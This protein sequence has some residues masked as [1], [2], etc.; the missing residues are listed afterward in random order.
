[1]A[2][3]LV[4]VRLIFRHLDATLPKYLLRSHG[5]SV[6]YGLIYAINPALIIVLVPLVSAYT[7]HV[8]P[9]EMIKWGSLVAAAS[10]WLLPSVPGPAVWPAS[11]P[12]PI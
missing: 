2:V 5:P 3:L 4:A 10:P 11:A 9:L 7:R 12:S 8:P 6:P 1:M